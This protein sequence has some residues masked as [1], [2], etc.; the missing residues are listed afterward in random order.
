MFPS[1]R[2]VFHLQTEFIHCRLQDFEGPKIP[3][4]LV[5]MS[6]MLYYV[7]DSLRECLEKAFS[8]LTPGGTMIIVINCRTTALGN[9]PTFV[10]D[11]SKASL[12]GE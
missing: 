8:W 2:Y 5:L 3:V 1:N 9:K 6:H 11:L 10:A 4:D 12:I 7:A